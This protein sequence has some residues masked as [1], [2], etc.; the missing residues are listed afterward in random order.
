MLLRDQEESAPS[1]RAL[2]KGIHSQKERHAAWEEGDLKRARQEKTFIHFV[3][4]TFIFAEKLPQM[5]RRSSGELKSSATFFSS[6]QS[7]FFS[8]FKFIFFSFAPMVVY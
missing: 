7:F 4:I 2:L 8:S 3:L 1:K 6:Q 5:V